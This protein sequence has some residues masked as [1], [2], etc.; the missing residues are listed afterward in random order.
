MR[1][2]T[3]LFAPFFILAASGFGDAHYSAIKEGN[4]KFRAGDY[5][6]AAKLYEKAREKS[7][8]GTARYNLGNALHKKNDFE[9]AAK[10]FGSAATNADNELARRARLNLA[11]AQNESGWRRLNAGDAPAGRRELESAAAGY[12]QVLLENPGN[13]AAKHNMEV[14]L[15]RLDE[16]KKKEEEQKEQKDKEGKGQKDRKDKQGKGDNKEAGG[17]KSQ[18][19]QKEGAKKEEAGM[20][21]EDAERVLQS[22]AREEEQ[23]QRNLRRFNTREREVEKDW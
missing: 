5:D 1:K 18:N 9:N 14:A 10:L 22:L 8:S 3:A 17:E 13:A 15:K 4:G 2:K 20:K 7:D 11:N 21:K 6:A 19:P 12:R 16:A 23:V